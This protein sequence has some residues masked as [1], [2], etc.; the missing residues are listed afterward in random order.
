MNLTGGR[1]TLI[2]NIC[3]LVLALIIN[4]EIA[5]VTYRVYGWLPHWSDWV[6]GLT[7]VLVMF[8]IRNRGLSYIFVFL[9]FAI[10]VDYFSMSRSVYLGYQIAIGSK[11]PFLPVILL[12]FLSLFCL[13]A[14]GAIILVNASLAMLNKHKRSGVDNRD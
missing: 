6:V 5:Y 9:H 1:A 13:T 2:L 4:L 12:F 7:P 3:A 8:I 14:Y 11:L 10:A